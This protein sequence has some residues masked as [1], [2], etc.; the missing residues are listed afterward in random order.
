MYPRMSYRREETV[1]EK[2][3]PLTLIRHDCECSLVPALR[4][5]RQIDHR[6]AWN[7]RVAWNIILCHKQTNKQA[8]ISTNKQTNKTSEK[9]RR[10]VPG[11]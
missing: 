5:C 2:M 11:D 8:D 4:R 1:S 10:E 3:K 9:E 6:A 7:S